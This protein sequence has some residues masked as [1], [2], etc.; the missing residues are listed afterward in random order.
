MGLVE[1][2]WTA[3]YAWTHQGEIRALDACKARWAARERAHRAAHPECVGNFEARVFSENGSYSLL[4]D[5]I[6]RWTADRLRALFG[7][8]VD[9]VTPEGIDHARYPA[10]SGPVEARVTRVGMVYDPTPKKGFADG[11]AAFE[12]VRAE[13]PEIELH[14]LGVPRRAPRFPPHVVTH[15]RVPHAAKV[16]LF[17]STQVWLSS[18]LEEGWGLVP[19]EAMACGNAV[20]TTRVGGTPYFAH[21]GD[22]ALVVE[23]GDRAALTAALRRVVGDGELRARLVERGGAAVRALTLEDTARAF[24]EAVRARLARAA[25]GAPGRA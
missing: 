14:L 7:L 17:H 22:T 20:V 25:E 21:D 18:S 4:F 5:P 9:A 12:A 8:E 13:C 16:A 3:L 6:S 24:R 2:L 11:Y 23:P 1:K 10:R 15:F 19:M